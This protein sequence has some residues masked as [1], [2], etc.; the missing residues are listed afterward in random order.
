MGHTEVC[1]ALSNITV[2]VVLGHRTTGQPGQKP[3]AGS[4]GQA[5]SLVLCSAPRSSVL[6]VL[7]AGMRR[8]LDGREGLP[9]L[10]WSSWAAPLY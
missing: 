6:Q 3:L 10:A 8:G 5:Q 7:G 2:A 4:C 9:T 1:W